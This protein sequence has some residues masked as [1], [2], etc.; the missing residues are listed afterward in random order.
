MLKVSNAL[1]QREFSRRMTYQI[2]NPD[3]TVHRIYRERCVS[4][5][6]TQR[7]RQ[8]GGAAVEGRGRLPLEERVCPCGNVQ[9]EQHVIE[10][11]PLTQHIRELYQFSTMKELFS[12]RLLPEIVCKITHEILNVFKE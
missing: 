4:V 9:T 10:Q 3:M 12:E 2:I 1:R 11:C 7:V 8:A 5:V 6:T